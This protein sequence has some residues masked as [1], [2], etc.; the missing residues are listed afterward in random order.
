MKSRVLIAVVVLAVIS[1]GIAG[2]DYVLKERPREIALQPETETGT[3][4]SSESS[5]PQVV[6]TDPGPSSSPASGSNSSSTVV[7]KG[8][9]TKKKVGPD[10]PAVL[11]SLQLMPTATSEESL[12]DLIH[13]SGSLT[14]VLLANNDRAAL[15][16]WVEND[17]VKTIFSAL[18]QA[19]QEQFSPQLKN[20]VDETRTPDTGPPTDVL[21]FFD[22]AISPEKVIFLRVRTRL[23][24]F[25]VA[26]KGTELVNR[27]IEELSK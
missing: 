14:M 22:P 23:Y 4:M 5:Q 3:V 7:K 27:L 18:K 9:S 10:V 6:P 19:L 1:A 11:A 15:F 16:S 8:V 20:L 2:A 24:E 12:L 26:E 13:G 25:H 21:S 17:D